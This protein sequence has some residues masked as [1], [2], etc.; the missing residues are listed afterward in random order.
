MN[1]AVI[2]RAVKMIKSFNKHAQ[3]IFLAEEFV[4]A[5]VTVRFIVLLL[6]RAYG[7]I[8]T[9]KNS[10]EICGAWQPA[11]FSHLCSTASGRRRTR[12]VRDEIYETSRWCIDRWWAWSNQRKVSHVWHGNAFRNTAFPRGRR[13]NLRRKAADNPAKGKNWNNQLLWHALGRINHQLDGGDV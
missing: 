3:R 2:P 7:W 8:I 5:A 11:S 13:T 1:E 12:N 9:K 4:E 6:K 10:L